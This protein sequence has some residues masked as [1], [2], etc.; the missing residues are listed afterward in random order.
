MW[1]GK[2][3]LK[4]ICA[5]QNQLQPGADSGFWLVGQLSDYNGLSGSNPLTNREINK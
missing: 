2:R 3:K 5:Y 1:K 4:K